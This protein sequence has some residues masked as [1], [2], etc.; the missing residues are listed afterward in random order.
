VNATFLG[1]LERA[2]MMS[3][4]AHAICLVVP[5]RW[6]EMSPLVIPEAMAHGVPVIASRI[7]GLPEL[8]ED[9]VTGLLF[10]PGEAGELAD[11]IATLAHDPALCRRLG[12][13][14]WNKVAGSTSSNHYF[15]RLMAAYERAIRMRSDSRAL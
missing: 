12:E 14:A 15:D 6:F 8:V 2:P 10:S 4:Y 3:F 13:A 11:R 1:F 9:G 5:S 7:G